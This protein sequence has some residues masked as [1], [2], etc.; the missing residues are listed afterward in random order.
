MLSFAQLLTALTGG[1]NGTGTEVAVVW[2]V[3]MPRLVLALL[4][5]SSAAMAGCAMQGLLRNPLADPSL[6]GVAGGAAFAATGWLALR[7][8]LGWDA[9]LPPAIALPLVA[10][11]GGLVAA[12]TVIALG[13]VQQQTS[14][15]SMLLAG[16][17]INALAAAGVGMFQQLAS[18]AALRDIS[19]WLFGSLGR[20]G[21]PELQAAAP[22]LLACCFGLWR[23]ARALDTLLLGEA[24]A[25]YLGTSVESCKRW[26]LLWV[27]LATGTAVA[28]A[29][30][31]GFIGLLVPHLMRLAVGPRHGLLMPAAAL[32]GASLLSVADTA[33]RSAFAPLELPVGVLTACFGAPCFLWLLR[34]TRLR[35]ALD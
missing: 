11:L 6:I 16:I 22:L 2:Q 20:S 31:I 15:G 30:L 33:A 25:R 3:R 4:I 32:F 10:A 8:T 28:L 29:G 35:L 24:E 13:Q 17:A 1:S 9:Y 23:Q 19:V 34:R 21:W 26:V 18:D 7:Q 12:T 14:V 27:V 5:G